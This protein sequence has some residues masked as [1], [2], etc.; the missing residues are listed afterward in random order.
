MKKVLKF[1]KC[2]ILKEYSDGRLFGS[3][4][5]DSLTFFCFFS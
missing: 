4:T 1:K 2:L 5:L 3:G